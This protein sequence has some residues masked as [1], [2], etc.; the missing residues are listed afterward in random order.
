MKKAARVNK[1]KVLVEEIP[2]LIQLAEVLYRYRNEDLQ[3]MKVKNLNP[4][5]S[6]EGFI[7]ITF[8]GEDIPEPVLNTADI[9]RFINAGIPITK[10]TTLGEIITPGTRWKKWDKLLGK[11]VDDFDSL[12]AKQE[13]LAG[14]CHG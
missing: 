2:L 9:V 12:L 11:F 6:Y 4:E 13:M 3:S 7:I 1:R 8:H 5:K 14:G 10:E